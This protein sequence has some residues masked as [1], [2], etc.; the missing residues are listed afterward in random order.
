MLFFSF[1]FLFYPPGD[2]TEGEEN[3]LITVFTQL[4]EDVGT[5]NLLMIN[6]FNIYWASTY[7][8]RI[9]HLK[10]TERKSEVYFLMISS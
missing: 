10:Y 6:S 7:M 8:P 2:P 5:L 4:T 9:R 3:D 1:P